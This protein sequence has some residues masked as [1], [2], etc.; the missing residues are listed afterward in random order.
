MST[1]AVVGRSL[2]D[3]HHAAG[4]DTAPIAAALRPATLVARAVMDTSPG[5]SSGLATPARR[6]AI[7][8]E[9]F[10]HQVRHSC[11]TAGP[12]ATIS[13]MRHL[14]NYLRGFVPARLRAK[15]R[16]LV[17]PPEEVSQSR[18]RRFRR[19]MDRRPRVQLPSA[20]PR[21]ERHAVG[22]TRLRVRA[23]AWIR[24][25]CGG[26]DTLRWSAEAANYLRS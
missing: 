2:P 9:H 6:E 17:R 4:A 21:I 14:R 15:A 19:E 12:I 1:G 24:R 8:T 18:L 26:R 3:R 25:R 11:A 7:V 13:G 20:A 5:L 10:A 22:A 16:Q 23:D